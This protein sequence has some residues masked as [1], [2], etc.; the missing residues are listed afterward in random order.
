VS[1]EFQSRP[2][3]EQLIVWEPRSQS[4]LVIIGST[5]LSYSFRAVVY[6]EGELPGGLEVERRFL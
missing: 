1:C 3:T 5:E 4:R 6:D 2:E